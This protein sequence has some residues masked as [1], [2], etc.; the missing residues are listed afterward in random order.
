MQELGTGVL[1]W[2]KSE[3]VSDRYG[4]VILTPSPDNEKSISLIQVNAGRR[5]RLV[6]I[7]KETRQSRHIGDLFHGVFPK[8]PKV[9]QKITLGEGSLFFEDGGVGLHPDDGR[10]TQWLD[11]CALYK[12]HEQTVTLCF[13]ELPNS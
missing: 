10:G 5:G 6:V 3:R 11:I 13:E 8:T 2:N 1:S 4:S 12:A 7:V 9:G